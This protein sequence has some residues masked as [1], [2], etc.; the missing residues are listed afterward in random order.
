MASAYVHET[1]ELGEGVSIGHGT[2]IWQYSHVRENATVGAECVI[3]RAVYIGPGVTIGNATKIQNNAM[4][5]D[6][7]TIGDGVFIGPAVVL[8]NDL[9]P[10]S[11]DGD[12]KPKR[13][14]DWTPRPIVV[15]TGA[16][17]GANTVVVAGVSVG[18]WALVGAGSTIISNVPPYALVVG[19]PGVQKGWV[20]RAGSRL[21]E[22]GDGIFECPVTAERFESNEGMLRRL[23]DGLIG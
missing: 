7:A 3:G 10:R 18:E 4:I 14:G 5:Y 1:A 23:G 11:V 8:T 20:G 22:R 21:I 16:S 17:I 9:Y 12:M 13:S 15:K 6:P 2:A 19:S